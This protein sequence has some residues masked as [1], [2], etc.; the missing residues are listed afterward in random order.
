MV[1]LDSYTVKPFLVVLATVLPVVIPVILGA[2][3]PLWDILQN[4][5]PGAPEWH[6]T[7]LDMFDSKK[8]RG[9]FCVASVDL[10][11]WRAILALADISQ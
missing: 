6:V 2:L 8:T 5:A 9:V 7:S 10:L 3:H 1:F 4:A 11:L